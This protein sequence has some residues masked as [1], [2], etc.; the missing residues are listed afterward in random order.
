MNNL[1]VQINCVPD[2]YKA[3]YVLS[4]ALY[5]FC[6][7]VCKSF[8]ILN[9]AFSFDLNLNKLSIIISSVAVS[10]RDSFLS[11]FAL[12]GFRLEAPLAGPVNMK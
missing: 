4:Y 9:W 7:V 12:S 6:S 8:E 10:L 1:R 3:F 5:C 11:S 2:L